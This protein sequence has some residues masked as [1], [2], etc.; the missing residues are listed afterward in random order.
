MKREKWNKPIEG[1]WASTLIGY[2]K[3]LE[4]KVSPEWKKVGEVMESFGLTYTRGGGRHLMLADMCRKG[5]LEMKKFRVIDVTG[6]RIM[7][8]NHYRIV[9]KPSASVT[10]TSRKEIVSSKSSPSRKHNPS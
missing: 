7:P 1:E 10:K 6:R 8:I 9:K 4:E 2:I 3:D 5:I